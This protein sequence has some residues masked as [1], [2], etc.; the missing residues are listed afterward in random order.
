MVRRA[1]ALLGLA[2]AVAATLVC[3]RSTPERPGKPAVFALRNVPHA[4][5]AALGQLLLDE[6]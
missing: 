4:A 5:F 2:S 6:A 3:C 1:F